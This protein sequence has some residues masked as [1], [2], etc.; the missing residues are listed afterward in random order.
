MDLVASALGGF[1]Y[2]WDLA[3]G[4]VVR[5]PGVFDLLGYT[6]SEIA[7]DASW[8]HERV[9]PDDL[10]RVEAAT[11]AAVNDPSANRLKAD[12]RIR[13]ADG[14]YRWIANHTWLVRDE[15]RRVVRLVGVTSDI[16]ALSLAVELGAQGGAMLV[17][18]ELL[19][20]ERFARADAQTTRDRMSFLQRLSAD[21]TQTLTR[22]SVTDVVVRHIVDAFG[23]SAGGVVELS[24]DGREFILLGSVGFKKETLAAWS[25]WPVETPTPA[26]DAVRTR[27]P[28]FLRN[29]DE[30]AAR[31][32]RPPA[33]GDA[34]GAWIALPLL[35]KDSVV[36][37]LTVTLRAARDFPSDER[38]F[39]QAFA[40]LCAQGLERA[41]L[42]ER[43]RVARDRAERLQA[44]TAVLAG[45]KTME[46]IGA[47]F[48]RE[49]R[50]ISEA[51]T[52]VVHRVS[53][54]GRYIEALGSSGY[55]AEY[56]SAWQRV[57]IDAKIPGTDAIRTKTPQWWSDPESVI[58]A[59]PHLAD[60]LRGATREA[61]AVVP[62]IGGESPLGVVSLGY[63]ERRAFDAG[64]REYI[65]ALGSR[66]AQAM[67]RAR[68]YEAEREARREAEGANKAKGDFLAMMSHELRTPLNAI[69]GYAELLE[70]EIRGP[71][72]AAQRND[73]GRI[74]KSQRVL[75][76]LITDILN[77]ARI[78][79]G[80]VQYSLEPICVGELV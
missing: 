13:H 53:A 7:S 71:L 57:P 61:L 39:M 11:R 38:R 32:S 10:T 45:T 65:L 67:E 17:D 74:R 64:L 9:H 73:I 62:L 40:D 36:G 31:F 60:T 4:I 69:D 51:S 48:S 44:M 66:C 22:A 80:Q 77:Y 52:C 29:R 5:S 16:A 54:D 70:M 34:S 41:R 37:A 21:L 56:A 79:A 24:D 28:V 59:Y 2:D 12:Y 43:E 42:Y 33:G 49:V 47:A 3:T 68:F 27:E 26:L 23:A 20:R 19:E 18:E 63:G 25:R 30:W 14:T 78:E 58:A 46:E 55:T 15:S 76:G 72:S 6:A 50:E 1:I 35:V 8:W 75:L